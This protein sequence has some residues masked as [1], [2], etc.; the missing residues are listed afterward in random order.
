MTEIEDCMIFKKTVAGSKSQKELEILCGWLMEAVELYGWSEHE[1][2]AINTSLVEA[3]NN[4][5]MH[6]NQ[7]SDSKGIVLFT[8]VSATTVTI[9]IRDEGNGFLPEMVPDPRL[10]ER[11]NLP[12][13]RGVFLIRSLMDKVSFNY[14]GNEITMEKYH[15]PDSTIK[16][17]M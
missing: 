17:A 5:I 2:F 6:G 3:I 12:C 13:G 7:F 8:R 11:V 15:C 10:P 1:M 14:S 16:A 9:T 4:A